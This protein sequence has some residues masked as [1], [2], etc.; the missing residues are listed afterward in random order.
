MGTKQRFRVELQSPL[1]TEGSPPLRAL[2]GSAKDFNKATDW[3]YT[4]ECV[5][6]EDTVFGVCRNSL[7]YPFLSVCPGTG[8]FIFLRLGF[9][10][11]PMGII[12]ISAFQNCWEN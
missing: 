1:R 12:I 4:A 9:C 7:C 2:G 3:G 10:I 6:G 5:L 8:Y 11:C